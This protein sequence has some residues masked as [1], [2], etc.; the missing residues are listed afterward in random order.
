[1]MHHCVD[2][3]LARTYLVH[4]RKAKRAAPIGIAPLNVGL[5][6]IEK[7]R[8]NACS[9]TLRRRRAISTSNEQHLGLVSAAR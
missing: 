2:P 1:M 8:C 7:E 4:T 3:L 9:D 6:C 5:P